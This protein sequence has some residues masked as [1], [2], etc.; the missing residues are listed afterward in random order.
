MRVDEICV[1]EEERVERGVSDVQEALSIG[2]EKVR[3][4]AGAMPEGG[5]GRDPWAN[6]LL[7][8]EQ[9]R[10]I[11]DVFGEAPHERFLAREVEARTRWRLPGI[12]QLAMQHVPCVWV[13]KI[14]FPCQESAD[15]IG[16]AVCEKDRGDL[17]RIH[18]GLLKCDFC[19]VRPRTAM[20]PVPGV[21]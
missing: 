18:S 14:V 13:D 10:A 11:G 4:V 20:W 12:P 2:F 19:F 3:R 16:I 7:R 5:Y 6:L 17:L 9:V 1:L 15:V 8:I 21:D